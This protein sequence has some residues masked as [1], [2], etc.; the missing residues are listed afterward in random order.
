MKKILLSLV[1][2]AGV[3]RGQTYVNYFLTSFPN[4]GGAFTCTTNIAIPTNTTAKV[5]DF[6]VTANITNA[7]VFMQ[8]PGQP[9]M[10]PSTDPSQVLG[11][12]VLGP[13]TATITAKAVTGSGNCMAVLV[14][15]EPVNT[16][17]ALQGFAVQPNGHS[18]TIALQ[19]SSNLV[20]WVTATNGTYPATNRA[21]FYRMSFTVQ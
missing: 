2:L 4:V 17:P 19:S 5:L 21:T 6:Q 14:E 11:I 16:T 3:A 10:A 12:P 15:F 9:A 18:A 20:N 13:A 8:Y 7:S 1:L